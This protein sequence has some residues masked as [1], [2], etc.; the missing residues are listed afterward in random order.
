[1]DYVNQ[2]QTQQISPV[3]ATCFCADAY[4]TG[5]CYLFLIPFNG[6]S[7]TILNRITVS[8][9]SNRVSYPSPKVS[10]HLPRVNR[11]F[12]KISGRN[13]WLFVNLPEVTSGCK[14]GLI[15]NPLTTSECIRRLTRLPALFYRYTTQKIKYDHIFD[16]FEFLPV[17]FTTSTRRLPEIFDKKPRVSDG[18][19]RKT[20]QYPWR[21]CK[22]L[23]ETDRQP[24]ETCNFQ[25]TNPQCP[26]SSS[27][28]PTITCL[29]PWV[30]ARY[31]AIT[32]QL[33]R[34][35]MQLRRLYPGNLSAIYNNSAATLSDPYISALY[36]LCIAIP[37]QEPLVF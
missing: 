28:L 15:R 11:S 6:F 20:L 36:G 13:P 34:I 37:V 32:N 1:M 35:L 25:R 8:V 26:T 30:T 5:K 2:P 24:G 22:L 31:P 21:K 16:R 4:R 23:D 7:G 10:S 17:Y 27:V 9:T 33:P 29:Y 14:A 18:F 19:L 3:P 12:R